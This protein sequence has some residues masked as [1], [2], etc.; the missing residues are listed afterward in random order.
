MNLITKRIK[1]EVINNFWFGARRFH[2]TR[3]I[4]DRRST[5][6]ILKALKR[7]ESVIF[8]LD[9]FMGPPLGVP[10]HFFGRKTGAAMGL[11]LLVEKT[12]V[13]VIP[14]YSYVNEKGK[15]VDVFEPE[16][17]FQDF[18]SRE[19]TIEKM[20]QIYTDKIEEIVRQYPEQWM[21]VHKR[22]KEFKH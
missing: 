3:L 17:P 20:T 16:I 15:I 2:G 21:W 8:V 13:P 1:N 18:G 10:V 9:Q 4:E 19:E 12:R 5:F 11:A 22:W 6:D 7:N 14:C